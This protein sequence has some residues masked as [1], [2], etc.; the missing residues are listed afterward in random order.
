VNNDPVNWVDLWGLS[1]SDIKTSFLGKVA[2][3]ISSLFK[4]D[5]STKIFTSGVTFSGTVPMTPGAVGFGVYIEPKNDTLHG[6]AAALLS[7]PV[8]APIGGIITASNIKDAG[9]Y[10]EASAGLGG[11]VSGSVTA[12][13]SIYESLNAA[14]GPYGEIG[15]SGTVGVAL[16]VDAIVDKSGKPIGSNISIG[17]GKG[18]AEAHARAGVSGFLSF[19]GK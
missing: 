8:T 6:I 7:N 9:L 15:T 13:G 10:G 2:N 19:F 12:T 5:G 17:V 1:A 3:T 18:G 11:G 16:G 4:D 14:R